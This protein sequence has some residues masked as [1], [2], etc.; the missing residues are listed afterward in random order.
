MHLAI[1][2]KRRQAPRG[3]GESTTPLASVFASGIMACARTG[4]QDLWEFFFKIPIGKSDNQG[5]GWVDWGRGASF[6]RLTLWCGHSQA[7]E[8]P[9]HTQQHE[10]KVE[11]GREW[12]SFQIL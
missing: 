1:A 6:K 2:M 12:R 7:R 4:Q 8:Q 11:V 5:A 10:E 9:A 3:A